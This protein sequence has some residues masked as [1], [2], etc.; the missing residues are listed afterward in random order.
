MLMVKGE[1]V[2]DTAKALILA[3][4]WENGYIGRFFKHCYCFCTNCS[5]TVLVSAKSEGYISLGAKIS[6]EI[7]DLKT[8]PGGVAY[9]SVRFWDLSCYNYTVT[10]AD[11]DFSIKLQSFAG[12]PDIYVNPNIPLGRWNYSNAMY[13]SY[14]HFWD[15]ELVLD[16]AIRRERGGLTGPYFICVYGRTTATYK[17]SAKNENHSE[18]LTP[19]L[20]ESGY[21]KANETKMYYFTD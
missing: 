20:A 2:P 3:P 7:Q 1:E 15:E 8:Y 17:L 19:G 11:K 13:N 6:G 10:D 14:D 5:Y 4:A 18:M 21:L 12:N 9:D 16:P